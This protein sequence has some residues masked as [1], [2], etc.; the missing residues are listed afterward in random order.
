MLVI[1]HMMNNQ[2]PTASGHSKERNPAEFPLLGVLCLGPA[3]GYDLCTE[4]RQRLGEIWILHTSHIYA[5]LAGLE[6]DGFVFHERIDQENRPAK[7]VFRITPEG[8]T[9][10]WTWMTSPVT[11]VRDIRMEFFAKL[12]FARLESHEVAAKLIDDQLK[13]CRDN[14]KRQMAR[15][16]AS[17]VEAER[18]VLDY[19]LAMLKTT[20]ACLRKTRAALSVKPRNRKHQSAISASTHNSVPDIT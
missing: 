16:E 6:K 19:R 5:L 4:L 10:F 8:R 11:N 15:K 20:V 9:L 1:I 2:N 7:K 17:N 13:V 3:H 12:Y 18:S 14:A